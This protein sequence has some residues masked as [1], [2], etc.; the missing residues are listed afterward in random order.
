MLTLFLLHVLQTFNSGDQLFLKNVSMVSFILLFL[1]CLIT[2]RCINLSNFVYKIASS[3]RQ[4][5]LSVSMGQ[6]FGHS[7][8]A[9]TDSGYYTRLKSS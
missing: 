9:A 8:V 2:Y 6:G 3:I 1:R 5:K 7:S 4:K